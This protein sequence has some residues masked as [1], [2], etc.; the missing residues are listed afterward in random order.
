MS[1]TRRV[2]TAIFYETDEFG[3]ACEDALGR[4]RQVIDGNTGRPVRIPANEAGRRELAD[5]VAA[6]GKIR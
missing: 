1:K 4:M 6:V 2:E 5:V 3:I